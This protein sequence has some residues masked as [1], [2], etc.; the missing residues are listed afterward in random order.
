VKKIKGGICAPKGFKA[1]GLYCGIKRSKKPDLALLYSEVPAVTSGV[2]TKNKVKAAPILISQENIRSKYSR[3]IISNAGNANCSTGKQGL[4]DARQMVNATASQLKLIPKD[5]LVTS[6]GSIGKLLPID[7]IVKAIP[8]LVEKLSNSGGHDLAR[9]IMTTDLRAKEIAIKLNGYTIGGV[10]KGSGMIHPNLATMHAFITTDAAVDRRVLDQILKKAVAKSFNMISVDKCMSTNDCVFL[11]ANGRSGVKL[12]SRKELQKFKAGVEFVCT[13]L[14]KEI[15]QDGEGATKLIT[16]EVIDAA[17]L[18]DARAA[19]REVV[20]SDL[21]KAAIFGQDPNWGRIIAALGSC[22]I[23]FDP[24]RTDIYL[25]NVCLVKNGEEN[26]FNLS[27][28]R[29]LFKRKEIIITCDLKMG[30]NSATAWGCDLSYD[31][32][33]INARY[34]T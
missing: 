12:R 13:H 15:A 28:V 24:N 18:T 6:T 7:L 34:H 26:D 31:Y 2:F 17:L 32:V 11:M 4:A 25:G 10:A 23:K 16:C 9:A 29:K 5:V 27:R 19:A 33:K 1:A 8:R 3:A 30:N 22:E 20:S 14:A 21:L